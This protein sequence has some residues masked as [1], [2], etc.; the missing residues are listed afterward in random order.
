MH[1]KLLLKVGKYKHLTVF[2]YPVFHSFWTMFPFSVL[3]CSNRGPYFLASVWV[4]LMWG[5]G[6]DGDVERERSWSFPWSLYL[7]VALEAMA[8][9]LMRI[10]LCSECGL[11]FPFQHPA[12]KPLYSECLKA[13]LITVVSHTSSSLTLEYFY[14][15]RS[16]T[17]QLTKILLVLT[18][19]SSPRSS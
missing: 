14:G 19:N 12:D 9:F 7:P 5:T 4:W 10:R 13:L 11:V 18:W 3:L 17:V 8:A 1:Y 2:S 16:V 6:R 15:K